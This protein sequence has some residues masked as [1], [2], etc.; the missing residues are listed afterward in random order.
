MLSLSLYVAFCVPLRFVY[1][2]F[3][4]LL[5]NAGQKI[6]FKITIFFYVFIISSNLFITKHA[7]PYETFMLFLELLGIAHFG[8][9]SF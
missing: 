7:L 8:F 1:V 5:Q 3:K 9:I 4:C 2:Q 6:I